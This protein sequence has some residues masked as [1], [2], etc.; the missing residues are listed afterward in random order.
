[1]NVR[2]S[3]FL[4]ATAQ[5]VYTASVQLAVALSTVTFVLVSGFDA[6]LGIGPAVFLASQAVAALPAGRLMD[7]AGRV[8]VLAGGFA[9]GAA[10]AAVT[11]LGV[12]LGRGSVVVAGFVVLGFGNGTVRL[13]RTAASDLV[14][15][16]RRAR[17]LA[18][19]LVGSVAGALLGPFVF[20]PLFQGK[21]VVASSLVVPWLA[22]GGLMLL[23]LAIVLL[24]RPDPKRV[25]EEL[26]TGL[27]PGPAAPLAELVR[28]PGA[29]PALVGAVASFGVMTSVMNLTG[30]VV[31]H[32]RGHAESAV[33]PIIAAHVF[34]MYG[35]V[36]LVA[37]LIDRVGRNRSLAGGLAAM[38][39]SAATLLEVTTV[40]ATAVAL[41]GLGLGWN[42]AFVAATAELADLTSPAERG[43]LLGFNDLVS[44]LLGAGLALLGGYAIAS[45]GVAALAL[46]GA[47]FAALPA[48]WIAGGAR[49]LAPAV[50]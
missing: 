10:G 48:L 43:K 29:I 35:L 7:R 16:E 40:Q 1:M 50:P 15:P 36:L 46:G 18:V 21:A 31:V 6:L 26:G 23:G 38:A 9:L 49:R 14:P 5:A 4:L 28:R 11:A 47:A 42:V 44:S 37:P 34:G 33:F 22:S 20:M 13:L 3:Q 24:V 27:E 2:R 17:G 45:L 32:E 19:V 41:F 8:P 12:H 39:I 25:A 30:Y